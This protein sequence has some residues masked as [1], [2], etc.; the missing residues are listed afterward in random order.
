MTTSKVITK[1]AFKG[2]IERQWKKNSNEVDMFILFDGK[3]NFVKKSIDYNEL[4]EKL[5]SL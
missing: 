1:R 3:H 5:Y 2:Y 4:H